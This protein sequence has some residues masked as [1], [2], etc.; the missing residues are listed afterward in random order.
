MT[1]SGDLGAAQGAT[2]LDEAIEAAVKE[3]FNHEHYSKHWDGDLA[4]YEREW[5]LDKEI[6]RLRLGGAS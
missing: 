1:T 6:A 5:H 2:W 4:D 3:V